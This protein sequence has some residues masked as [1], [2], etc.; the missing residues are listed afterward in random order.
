M[1]ETK[2]E[3]PQYAP[4]EKGD[5]ILLYL[6]PE[7]CPPNEQVPEVYLF[8]YQSDNPKVAKTDWSQLPEWH[9][10][11]D[12]PTNGLK[13]YGLTRAQ[14]EHVIGIKTVQ[15]RWDKAALSPS[16]LADYYKNLHDLCE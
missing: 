7:E 4:L 13:R 11:E 14:L 16:A 3:T 15:K 2:G 6:L 5:P 8:K 1:S 12:N 10:Y 9:R